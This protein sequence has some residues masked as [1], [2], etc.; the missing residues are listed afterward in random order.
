MAKKAKSRRKIGRPRGGRLN[1][2]EE[3][4]PAVLISEADARLALQ[5][6]RFGN[7]LMELRLVECEDCPEG[8]EIVPVCVRCDAQI[9]DCACIAGNFRRTY[10]DPDTYDPDTD[11]YIWN[12][13]L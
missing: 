9:A 6:A 10:I 3:E 7:L 1:L 2:Q 4:G 8:E 13:E 5:Q 11:P 12:T